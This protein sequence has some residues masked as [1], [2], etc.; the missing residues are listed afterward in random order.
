MGLL[1]PSPAGSIFFGFLLL[2][3]TRV[4]GFNSYLIIKLNVRKN[5]AKVLRTDYIQKTTLHSNFPW[6][7]QNE[8][9]D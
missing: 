9:R 3:K 4:G 5:S 2:T 1:S 8:G 7:D 6:F